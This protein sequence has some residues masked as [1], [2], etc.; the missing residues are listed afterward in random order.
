[1]KK[2]FISILSFVFAVILFGTVSFAWFSIATTNVVYDIGLGI[3]TDNKFKIS[4][5]GINYYDSLTHDDIMN[6]VGNNIKLLDVTSFDG[7][8]F[9]KGFPLRN[10][11]A[12]ANV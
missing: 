10:E 1:M 5:D 11:V 2:L 12:I 3:S 4:L 9:S 8:N 6:V 7:I